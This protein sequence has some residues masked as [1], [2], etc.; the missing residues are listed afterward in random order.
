MIHSLYSNKESFKRLSIDAADAGRIASF[1]AFRDGS[2]Y[3]NDA[4]LNVLEL[5][6]RKEAGTLTISITELVIEQRR[7]YC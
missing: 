3:E 4:D 7:S 1:R 5:S 6:V 2:L